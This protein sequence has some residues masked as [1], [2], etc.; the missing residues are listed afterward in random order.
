MSIMFPTLFA[1][2]VKNLGQHTKRGS[3]FM[4]MSIV[5]GALP[6]YLMGRV[7]EHSFT[8]VADLLP[9]GCFVVVA[10]YARG[11]LKKV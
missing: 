9:L 5:D 3:S 7:A 1:M 8:A 4:I 6:P 10:A 2:G 11:F